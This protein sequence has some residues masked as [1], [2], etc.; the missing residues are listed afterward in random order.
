MSILYEAFVCLLIKRLKGILF[1]RRNCRSIPYVNP[2][3]TFIAN[4]DIECQSDI[5]DKDPLTQRH[6][7]RKKTRTNSVVHGSLIE[8]T[9]EKGTWQDKIKE[10]SLWMMNHNVSHEDVSNW[11]KKFLGMVSS[12]KCFS[13]VDEK[14]IFEKHL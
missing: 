2:T 4:Y 8:D 3:K 6:W 13:T 1:Q 9:P 11:L 12:S 5:E 14:I 10:Y 7:E